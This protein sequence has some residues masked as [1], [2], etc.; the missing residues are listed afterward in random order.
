VKFTDQTGR[1]V[2]REFVLASNPGESRVPFHLNFDRLYV[3]MEDVHGIKPRGVQYLHGLLRRA[4]KHAVDKGQLP[5]NPTDGAT[6][7]KGKLGP[8]R[9]LTEKQEER[10][11]AAAKQDPLSAL[12]HLLLDAGLRPGEALALKW[13]HDTQASTPDEER[14]GCIDFEAKPMALVKVRATLARA[15]VGKAKGGWKLN[16]TKTENSVR[17]VPINHITVTELQRWREAQR[18]QKRQAGSLWREHGFVFTS[19]TGSPLAPAGLSRA[20]ERVLRRADGG[21]GDLGTWGPEPK[22]EN[23]QRGRVADRSFTPR[24]SVYVLRHTMASLNYIA[25]IDL[26]LLSRRLGHSNYAFTFDRYGRGVKAE[27]TTAVA[28]NTMRRWRAGS[29]L[30]LIG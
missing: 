14:W 26:G 5:R 27:N 4:L 7:P 2:G 16:P 17:E 20:W 23:G 24:F 12:W 25:G 18:E 30:K 11:V 8:A 9:Y 28:E 22:R 6:V 1:A 15:G 21:V 29:S 10:F 3:A 19:G 13:E